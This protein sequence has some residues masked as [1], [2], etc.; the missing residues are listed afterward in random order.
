MT[1]LL[2]P[3]RRPAEPARAALPLSGPPP[4]A[5]PAW[6]E[7]A[8][9]APYFVTEHGDSLM[10]AGHNGAI[11]WPAL[12]LLF[13]RRDPAAVEARLRQLAASGVTC[14]RLMLEYCHREHR[15]LERP[16]GVFVPNMVHLWDDL[17]ALC[18][19][20]GIRLLL[21]PFDTFWMWRRW[22]HHPYCAS[23]GGPCAHPSRLLLSRETRM[24]IKC[25]LEFA[26]AHI[27]A[28]GTIDD[29]QDTVAPALDMGRIVRDLLA[30]IRDARP[31]LD[32]EHGPIHTF[33]D[34]HR[35]LPEPFDDEYFRHI[36][37]A[38][39][40]SGG[41]GGGMRWPNRHPHT[42]TPGMHDAQRALSAFLPLVDWGHLPRRN[43]SAEIKVAPA[44]VSVCA[45]GDDHQCVAWLVRRDTIGVDGRLRREAAPVTA[46]LRVPGLTSGTYRT[47]AWDT[48]AG[49]ACAEWQVDHTGMGPLTLV[50]PPF[51]ADVA[52]AVRRTGPAGREC[53]GGHVA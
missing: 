48:A 23:N 24:A 41:A 29:P 12:A 38:H 50:L 33:K 39:L 43:T 45:C 26:S 46:T 44:T 28:E 25:R 22:R 6:I 40:A 17:F 5:A 2:R 47:T 27:Y 11:T 51:V 14:L 19:R 4:A 18:E 20:T 30:E 32:S 15:Y 10:P 3:P 53:L 8:R 52:L 35:T 49:R 42:L 7:R 9:D 1:I 37:W 16:A 21:T 31:F 36:Q 34:H 13:R